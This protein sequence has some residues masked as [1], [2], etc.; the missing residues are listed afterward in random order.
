MDIISWNSPDAAHVFA[1][2]RELP[3][4]PMDFLPFDSPPEINLRVYEEYLLFSGE[5]GVKQTQKLLEECEI[6]YRR[7]GLA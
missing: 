3:A 5:Y 6:E 7:V 1:W 2:L 4:D